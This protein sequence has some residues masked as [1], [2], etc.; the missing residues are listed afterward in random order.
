MNF[1]QVD[2]Q[3]VKKQEENRKIKEDLKDM[4]AK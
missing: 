4:S 3:G 2:G 1:Q